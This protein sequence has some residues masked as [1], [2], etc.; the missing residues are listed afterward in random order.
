MRFD[1]NQAVQVLDATPA[2]LRALLSGLDDVWSASGGD[3]DAAWG[4]FDVLGHL[5]HGEDTDWIPRAKIILEQSGDRTFEAFDR[6]A[7]FENSKGKE[8]GD[9]LDEF[10]SKRS[11]S[12]ETL[13]FWRLTEEQLA[14]KGTHPELGEVDL[15]Q[16]IATWVVHDLTHIR[17]IA[18]TIAKKY[19]GEVGP[20]RE[21]LSILD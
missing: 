18:T 8:V 14:L 9:L 10:G 5:I 3:A 1:L 6:F 16:L 11:Q 21:Y 12:L 4:P 15:R 19:A 7:Q 13:V 2:T 20:W 17:Q